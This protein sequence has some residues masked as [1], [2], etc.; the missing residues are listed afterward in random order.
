MAIAFEKYVRITSGVV[1]NVGVRQ[2]ELILRIFT[3]CPFISPDEALEFTDLNNIRDFF[4][5]DSEEY[6]RAQFYF[7]WVSKQATRAKKISFARFAPEGTNPAVYGGGS[8]KTLTALQ[9]SGTLS[10]TL[11]D[12][13]YPDEV[14]NLTAAASFADA[15]AILQTAI[16]DID[17]ALEDATVS[18]DATTRRFALSVMGGGNQKISI[19]DSALSRALEWTPETGASFITGSDARDAAQTVS[20]SAELSNNFA[21]FLF[22]TPLSDDDHQAIAAWNDAQNVKFIYVMRAIGKTTAQN[23]FNTLSGYAGCAVTLAPVSAEFPEMAPAIVLAAT[24]YTRRNSTCNYMFQQFNLTPSVDKTSDSDMFDAVRCNYYGVTQT[25]GQLLAFYQRGILMG[26]SSAPTDMNTYV[27]E[28]W[29]KDFAGSQIMALLLSLQ[30]VSANERGRAQLINILLPCVDMALFNGA[31]SVG[32]PLI[33]TQKAFITEET[34]DPDAW[35]QVQDKG[36]WLNCTI[37]TE[38]TD[39]GRTEYYAQYILIY[40]KDDVIRRVEGSHELI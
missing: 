20:E 2:R 5:M 37:L 1:G 15:A 3:E 35:R 23:A 10:I 14:V 25:A 34:G 9:I 31:I 30:K 19:V 8:T 21:S 17:E 11:G 36:F 39:D 26:G 27:N 38:V 6:R 40:S 33:P 12:T 32:K 24:D 22:V 29:L 16:Q 4:G 28:I 13:T 7:A 18:Y